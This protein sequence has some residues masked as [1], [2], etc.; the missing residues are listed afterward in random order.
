MPGMSREVPVIG[1]IGGIGSGKSHVAR[2]LAARRR[3]VVVDADRAG[4]KIL[5]D[6]EVKEEIRRR[7][8]GD[9]FGC[10]G[11]IERSRLGALVFWSDS[12]DRRQALNE[13]MHPRIAGEMRREIDEARRTNGVEAVVV[14]AA[15]LLEAGWREQCDLVVYVH[16]SWEDRLERVSRTRGWSAAELQRREESQLPL[17]HKRAQADAVVDNTSTGRAVEELD[18]LLNERLTRP[19][20][21]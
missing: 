1:L 15:L 14:D 10:N 13:I 12:P 17:E 21:G 16:S 19:E 18:Q 4:H 11:E 5:K 8:G 20:R 9:V 7:F 6:P 3:I 2:E